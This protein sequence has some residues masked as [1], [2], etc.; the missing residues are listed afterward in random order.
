MSSAANSGA[1]AHPYHH[2]GTQ[3]YTASTTYIYAVT[4]ATARGPNRFG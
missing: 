2:C 1:N 3:S 4:N